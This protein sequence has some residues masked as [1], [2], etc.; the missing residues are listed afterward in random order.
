MRGAPYFEHGLTCR[1]RNCDSVCWEM[2]FPR[3]VLQVLGI[4]VGR[5]ATTPLPGRCCGRW[6]YTYWPPFFAAIYTSQG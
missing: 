6:I 4:S 3:F 2:V 5:T 1:G